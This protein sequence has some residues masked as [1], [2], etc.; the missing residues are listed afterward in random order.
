M[1]DLLLLQLVGPLDL[2]PDPNPSP[3]PSPGPNPNPSPNPHQVRFVR[4]LLVEQP[5]CASCVVSHQLLPPM[6]E[7]LL[8]RGEPYASP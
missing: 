8:E 4:M 6:L 2:N 5:Q 7:M 3:N 1:S